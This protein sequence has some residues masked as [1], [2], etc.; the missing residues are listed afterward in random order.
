MSV[1]RS[2]ENDGHRRRLQATM[3]QIESFPPSQVQ[4]NSGAHPAQSKPKRTNCKVC[5]QTALISSHR[6]QGSSAR[7]SSIPVQCSVQKLEMGSSVGSIR[8]I[9]E[10]LTCASAEAGMCAT[11]NDANDKVVMEVIK[12][13]ELIVRLISWS[14]A[15]CL[16]PNRTHGSHTR[17]QSS[18]KA[19]FQQSLSHAPLPLS[20]RSRLW[21]AFR[22]YS[23]TLVTLLIAGR[24]CG[25]CSSHYLPH[26]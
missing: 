19:D 11:I 2:E 7:S 4:S 25:G 1:E 12:G 9:N 10:E 16:A 5:R 21:P 22:E 18:V 8:A 24:L 20:S 3:S 13:S 14:N 23:I 15:D 6:Q 17:R 26:S